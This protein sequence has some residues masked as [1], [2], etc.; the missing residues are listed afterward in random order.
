MPLLHHVNQALRAHV[1]FKLDT[2]Y[3]IKTVRW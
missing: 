1:I 3:M 2:D